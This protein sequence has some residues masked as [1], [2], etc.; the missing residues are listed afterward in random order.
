MTN[1]DKWNEIV[2]W[3]TDNL[4]AS[5]NTIQSGWEMLFADSD[6]FGYSFIKKE[7][8]NQR[9][10]RLGSKDRVIPDIIIKGDDKDLF[11][12]ELKQLSLFF[13]NK[14]KDQLFS[15]LKQLELNIGVLVCH[16]IYVYI[17][18]GNGNSAFVK[19]P[20]EK[21]NKDGAKFVELFSKGNFDKEKVKEFIEGKTKKDKNIK[22]MQELITTEY[23]I[24]LI[25]ND[26]SKGY[27]QDE[28][29]EALDNFNIT[30]NKK[31]KMLPNVSNYTYTKWQRTKNFSASV[32]ARKDNK[33][34]LK[35]LRLIYGLREE[36]KISDEMLRLF[37]DKP[38]SQQYLGISFKF[39]TD[40]HNEI[41]DRCG[42]YRYYPDDPIVI[43]G[44]RYW[45]CSQWWDFAKPYRD[46]F[47][48]NHGIDLEDTK[49]DH[50]FQR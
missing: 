49:Y 37:Q 30:I 23:V 25:K 18:Y 26:L 6:I 4:E 12:V 20:L 13:D 10:I 43:N 29:E 33:N 16:D 27:N 48:E 41:R 36:G 15:Y 47:A 46:K 1:Q 28:I 35:A 42:H 2:E 11:V 31:V 32:S 44:N 21:D 45:I 24:D 7:I 39:L 22:E 34:K 5:E 14:M 17:F 38:S 50:C 9:S 19:I 40:D 8:D 3:C